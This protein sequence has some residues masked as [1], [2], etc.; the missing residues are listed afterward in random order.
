[1]DDENARALDELN[2]PHLDSVHIRELEA[3]DPKLLAVKPTRTLSEY[4][5]TVKPSTCLHALEGEDAPE[6]ITYLDADL[7][8]HTDP[9]PMFAELLWR[10]DRGRST[11][12]DRGMHRG[13]HTQR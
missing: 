5:W 7:M 3:Y 6:I 2:R 12:T 10:V 13:G 9:E 4:C 11:H 1:M 8:F